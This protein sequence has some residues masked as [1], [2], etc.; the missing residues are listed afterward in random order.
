MTAR[1][2]KPLALGIILALGLLTAGSSPAA[3][4]RSRLEVVMTCS[5]E[6]FRPEEWV[7]FECVA[8]LTN[9]SDTPIEHIRAGVVSSKGAIPESFR[10]LYRINGV[11][12][13]P[14]TVGEN[15]AL[16]PGQTDEFRLVTLLRMNSEG[17]YEGDWRVWSDEEVL[18]AMPI[19][20]EARLG[21]A[22]PPQTIEV[23][24][25]PVPRLTGGH[26]TYQTTITNHSETSV[27]DVR[28]FERYGEGVKLVS[29]EPAGS[30]DPRDQYLLTIPIRSLAPGQTT[31]VRTD[32]EAEHFGDCPYVESAVLVEAIISGDT[33]L[34]AARTENEAICTET[35]LPSSAAG[36]AP[37]SAPPVAGA[38]PTGD[39]ID[40]SWLAVSLLVG[41]VGLIGTAF[42]IRR[43]L[44]HDGTSWKNPEARVLR[45]H[46]CAGAARPPRRPID[47]GGPI[48]PRHRADVRSGGLST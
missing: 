16:Q 5:P 35:L 25:I 14:E 41:G 6:V 2:L 46:S 48:R 20:Y 27:T 38:G 24:Q 26:L 45:H 39:A 44:C 29:S 15:G 11:P 28:L 30:Q 43:R 8:R 4:Q 9:T 31:S 12:K 37:L 7:A 19:R 42:V 3:G 47:V 10:I 36:H 17:A 22:D 34:F 32:Y 13:D 21:A 1:T 23:I 40:S 33:E 18:A